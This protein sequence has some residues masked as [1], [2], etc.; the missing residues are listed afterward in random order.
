MREFAEQG[1]RLARYQHYATLA[2]QVRVGLA[3]LGIEMAVPPDESSV[4]LH[5]YRLPP[6]PTYAALHDALKA[7]G[8]VIYAGQ[9]DLSMT[10]FRISIMGNL[11]SADI[12]RLLKCFARLL[13]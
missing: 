10:L 13:G 1:G 7:Q 6:G 3:E 9:G 2:E 12:D 5:A 11:I 4:V 8:S